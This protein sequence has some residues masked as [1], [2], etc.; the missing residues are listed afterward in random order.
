VPSLALSGLV[1]IV[2]FGA[3][4]DE[5]RYMAPVVGIACL[6]LLHVADFSSLFKSHNLR[7]FN[8][9]MICAVVLTSLITAIFGIAK[10]KD[11]M[12]GMNYQYL[13]FSRAEMGQ[14]IEKELPKNS[15]ILSEDIGALSYFSPSMRY[16]DA[17]GLTN[18]QL[19]TKLQK[20]EEYS[21][22]VINNSPQYMVGTTDKNSLSGSEWIFDNPGKYFD[23]KAIKVESGCSFREAFTKQKIRQLPREG[24]VPLSVTLWKLTPK[25]DCRLN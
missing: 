8:V 21:S 18:H 9:V 14:W 25:G 19:L 16:F 5:F 24:N 15:I 10:S 20:G 23:A 4:A 1:T 12:N 2:I 11:I 22:I 6:N 13:Q 3:Y 7:H 17:S